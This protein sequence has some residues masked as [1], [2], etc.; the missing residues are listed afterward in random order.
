MLEL[1]SSIYSNET[2]Y[3]EDLGAEGFT[4]LY[5]LYGLAWKGFITHLL[6]HIHH[7]NKALKTTVYINI[8]F[9]QANFWEM[10]SRAICY[11]QKKNIRKRTLQENADFTCQED[12]V[13]I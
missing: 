9:L 8:C 12:L 10:F 11:S 7:I 4:W 6:Q 3:Q 13:A 1:F 5:L 2:A